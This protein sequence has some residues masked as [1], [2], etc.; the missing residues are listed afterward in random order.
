MDMCTIAGECYRLMGVHVV[1][2]MSSRWFKI[3]LPVV[4]ASAED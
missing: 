4:K 2:A 1:T 3:R